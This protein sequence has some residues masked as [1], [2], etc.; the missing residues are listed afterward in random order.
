MKYSA[1]V[2]IAD[3]KKTL[4]DILAI[5]RAEAKKKAGL[6]KGRLDVHDVLYI[7]KLDVHVAVFSTPDVRGWRMKD[8]R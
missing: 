1:L 5:A 8:T 3:K 6:K 2:I 7:P 4:G